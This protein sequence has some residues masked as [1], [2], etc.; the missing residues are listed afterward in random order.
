MNRQQ[1]RHP[2]APGHGSQ[3]AATPEDAKRLIDEAFTDRISWVAART[4]LVRLTNDHAWGQ[5]DPELRTS[6]ATF[7]ERHPEPVRR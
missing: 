6:I 4:I 7:L 1:R 2:D 5:L 3:P